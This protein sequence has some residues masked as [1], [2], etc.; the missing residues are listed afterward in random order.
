M[1]F[2]LLTPGQI[3]NGVWRVV[4]DLVP[5]F[6]I[7]IFLPKSLKASTEPKSSGMTNYLIDPLWAR[8]LHNSIKL[9][10]SEPVHHTLRLCCFPRSFQGQCLNLMAS[11]ER[12][13]HRLESGGVL[14]PSWLHGAR[15]HWI[16]R[17]S[18]RRPGDPTGL[19]IDT[20]L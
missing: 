18:V 6:S 7:F 4:H 11:S 13:G 9:N 1:S 8:N 15:F 12:D 10:Q 17:N 19:L 14:K 20:A 16:P 2:W 5:Q 3:T